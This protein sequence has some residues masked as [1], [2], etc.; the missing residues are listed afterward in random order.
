[1]PSNHPDL[2]VVKRVNMVDGCGTKRLSS[3]PI[4]ECYNE[5]GSHGAGVAGNCCAKDNLGGVVGGMPGARITSLII[6]SKNGACEGDDS[7]K[8]FDYLVANA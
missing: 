6:C 2:N 3:V 1:M 8:A 7:L 5:D 4:L